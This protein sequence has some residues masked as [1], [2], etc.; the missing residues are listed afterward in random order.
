MKNYREM[1]L[2]SKNAILY[3]AL[4]NHLVYHSGI[5]VALIIYLYSFQKLGKKFSLFG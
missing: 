4:F 5:S 2:S 1:Y 3:D